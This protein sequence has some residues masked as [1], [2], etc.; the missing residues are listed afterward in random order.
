MKTCNTCKIEKDE[1]DFYEI[2]KSKTGRREA[3]CKKCRAEVASR[4]PPKEHAV[5]NVIDIGNKC[6]KKC[7][8]NKIITDF[9]IN[10]AF[11]DGREQICKICMIQKEKEKRKSK[12]IGYST[13]NNKGAEYK[14]YTAKCEI[15]ATEFDQLRSNH[16][17]CHRCT[18][19]VRDLMSNLAG[20]RNGKYIKCSSAVGMM[21]AKKYLATTKCCHC[22]RDF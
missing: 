6:C 7:K 8:E 12:V 20:S 16:K 11:K 10:R 2:K 13:Y 19:L 15:C 14:C 21:V 17:R 3:Q 4:R 9:R 22:K 18:Y 5:Y 1:L